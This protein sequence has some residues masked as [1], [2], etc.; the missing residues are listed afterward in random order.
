M[1]R[2]SPD[3]YQDPKAQGPF[4]N[5]FGALAGLKKDLPSSQ[6]EVRPEDFPAEPPA[7]GPARAVVRL[8]R[9]G[10]SGKEV[11]VVEGLGLAEA[12]LLAWLSAL[13]RGLGCGGT[14]EDGNLVLQ[15]DHRRK[16][17]DLLLRRGVRR[18]S[19]G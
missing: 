6:P 5:P 19:K 2:K 18:V 8:E 1:K 12:E 16:L 10:R 17:P 7:Q 13:R 3:D 4:H 11:T 15:G 14:V 9:S